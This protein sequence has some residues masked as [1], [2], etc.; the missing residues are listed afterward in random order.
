MVV[1]VVEKSLPHNCYIFNAMGYKIALALEFCGLEK[2]SIG[3]ELVLDE[4]L[5]DITSPDFVQPYC[6][7]LSDEKV[8]NE[9]KVDEETAL[10]RSYGKVFVLKRIYG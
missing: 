1:C 10:L 2:P 5:L 4:K 3:D 7:K 8:K 9:N 6:F